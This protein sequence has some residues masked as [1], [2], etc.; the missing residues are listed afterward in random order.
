MYS[1][2]ST[3]TTTSEPNGNTL[4][5]HMH[6]NNASSVGIGNSQQFSVMGPVNNNNVAGNPQQLQQ[7]Q[8]S[9]G[10][11]GQARHRQGNTG[12]S[13]GSRNGF[14]QQNG[15]YQPHQQPQIYRVGSGGSDNVSDAGS[16]GSHH[17]RS[18]QGLRGHSKAGSEG[19]Y[20]NQRSHHQQQQSYGRNEFG[21]QL[22]VSPSLDSQASNA[23][24]TDSNFSASNNNNSNNNHRQFVRKQ[25]QQQQIQQVPSMPM[26]YANVLMSDRNLAIDNSAGVNAYN[27]NNSARNNYNNGG[28]VRRHSGS[29]TYSN[30]SGGNNFNRGHNNGVNGDRRYP[31]GHHN[32]NNG[33]YKHQQHQ[34]KNPRHN[35]AN[36]DTF[37]I[38]LD[39][40]DEEIC[41]EA[42]NKHYTRA[43][44]L[45]PNPTVHYHLQY[46]AAR[47]EQLLNEHFYRE[48][49][50]V[51]ST[52]LNATIEWLKGKSVDEQSDYFVRNPQ[53]N[54]GLLKAV[55]QRMAEN[56]ERAR[57]ESPLRPSSPDD[58]NSD[59]DKAEASD[60]SDENEAESPV[61]ISE[62]NSSR[63]DA[64][65]TKSSHHKVTT[66][67]AGSKSSLATATSD[68]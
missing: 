22:T 65:K 31:N 24:S 66:K 41:R 6:N 64:N 39:E 29:S 54:V 4:Q 10:G 27:P 43:A 28:N 60:V 5:G 2:A 55:L 16:T 52:K 32:H 37:V 14:Q 48:S 26:N 46:M 13:Y 57:L 25:P 56:D 45:I 58:G 42:A 34:H 68:Q 1:G 61:A 8:Q 67:A 30:G 33:G 35:N 21:S 9:Q 36:R 20:H 63:R 19:Q 12:N 3:G 44:S 17:Q 62:V 59:I 38:E 23:S 15:K 49:A 47:N 53:L 51:A 18:S 11:Q 50:Y 7:Q 40:K